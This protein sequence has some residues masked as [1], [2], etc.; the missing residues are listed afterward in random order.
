MANT[1]TK[2]VEEMTIE[3]LQALLK[4][5]KAEAVVANVEGATYERKGKSLIITIPDVTK[6]VGESKSGKSHMVATTHGFVNIGD[7]LSLGLNLTK[8][9]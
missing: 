7:G 9:K 4:A 2:K 5:K 8:K 1:T 6:V 3:E